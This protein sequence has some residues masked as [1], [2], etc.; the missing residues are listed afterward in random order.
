MLVLS[1]ARLAF[2]A[3]PKTGSTALEMALQPWADIAF[4]HGRKHMNL[5]RFEAQVRPWLR[6]TFDMQPETAAVMREPLAQVKSWYRYRSDTLGDVSFESFLQAVISPDPPPFA[7]IGTQLGFL[8]NASGDVGVDHLFAYE[9]QPKLRGWL[10]KRVG[11]AL[12][13]KVRNVSP[14]VPTPLSPDA[15]AAFRAARAEEYALYDRLMAA[16]GRL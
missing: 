12:N 10:E 3:M 5:R 14:D 2:L 6:E 13:I 7:Q 8:R 11:G 15:E 1:E 9:R 16:G 4:R